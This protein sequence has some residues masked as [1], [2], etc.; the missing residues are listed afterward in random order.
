M[1]PKHDFAQ[2]LCKIV[3]C[4]NCN[5]LVIWNKYGF[6]LIL[7]KT[8]ECDSEGLLHGLIIVAIN[9]RI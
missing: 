9:K 3:E 5:F 2:E 6:Y 7:E 8:G 4:P 1:T